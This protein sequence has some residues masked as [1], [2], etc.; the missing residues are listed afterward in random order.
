M[1]AESYIN[2][3]TQ[4]V[5]AKRC[6]LTAVCIFILI[7]GVYSAQSMTQDKSSQ[8]QLLYDQYC[9]SC[10]GADLHGGNAQSLVDKVWNYGDERG[11]IMQNIKFGITHLGMPAY[12]KTFSDRQINEIIN[13]LQ[14]AEKT[15]GASE[16]NIPTELQTQDYTIKVEIFAEG[17][18]VPW[19]IDF[20]DKRQALITERPGRLRM[21]TDGKLSDKAIEGTPEVLNEGQGGLLDVTVDPEYLKNGWIYLAYS[22]ELAGQKKENRPGAMTRLVRGR[23]KDNAWTD[24]QVIYQ[25]PPESYLTTRHHYGCRIVFDSKGYLYFGIGERGYQDQ[26]QDLSRPNGKIHRIGRDGSIPQDNPFVKTKD[27]LPTI[28]CYGNRNPQGLAIHPVTD[29]LWET[30]HGPLGGDEVNLIKPGVNY[31]WPVITYGRNYNGM[32]I[33]DLEEKPGMEQPILYWKPSIAACGLD[34]YRGNLFKLWQNHLLAGALKYEEVR[35]L[36]IKGNRV[37]HDEVILKGAGRVRDVACGPDGAIYV[38]LN[39]PGTV[40]RLTPISK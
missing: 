21:V 1:A 18:N 11:Y 25:A 32:I 39:D 33:S 6:I 7:Y 4:I 30:E 36:D 26:A 14:E 28:Y 5:T 34:F 37:L 2:G 8:G 38:V 22:H 40:L 23:I 15:Y 12:E 9:A 13:Y 3:F 29:H 27:A 10:H 16:P 20:I 17:L 35:L 19:S 24:Q 31:G